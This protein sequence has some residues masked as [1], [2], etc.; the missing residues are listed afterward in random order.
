MLL[1]IKTPMLA[2][3]AAASIDYP[4]PE[5]FLGTRASLMLDVVFLAMFGVILILGWSIYQVRRGQYDLHKRTQIVL[6]LVL[7]VAVTA[8]EVEMRVYGWQGRAAGALGGSPGPAVWNALYVH[9][10]FAI[11]TAVLWPVVIVRALRQ[12]PQ[13]PAP[14]EHSAGHRRWARLAAADMVMT[15]VTGW[16]FYWLAFVR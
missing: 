10:V 9:L 3:V 8:F 6:G 7:L 13:P 15:S 5:G 12:F 4:G 1:S 16:V 14:G 2:Q 11:T